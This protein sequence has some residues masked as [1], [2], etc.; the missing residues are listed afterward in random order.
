MAELAEPSL[1]SRDVLIRVSASSINI[2]DIHF[3]EGTF[4]GG[5]PL[6]PR[7]KPHAPVTP[8]SDVA[9][10]VVAVGRHVQSVQVGDAVFGVQLPFRRGGAWAELC[11]VDERWITRKPEHVSFRDAAACGVSGLV[12]LFAMN[13]M[14]IRAGQQI[15]ILGVTGGIGTIAAQL[16]I[17]AGAKVIGVCGTRNIDRAYRL[18]C[19]LVMDYSQGP[20]DH[21][22]R[23]HGITSVDRVLD[24][25]GGRHNERMGQSILQ[26]HGAY[27]TVVGPERFVGDRRLGW[28]G[29]LANLAHVGYRS[30]SSYFRGPRYILT[31]PGLNAGKQLPNIAAAASAGVLP[32]IDSTVPFELAPI[33]D[34]LRRAVAHSNTGRIVIE[35]S[36]TPTPE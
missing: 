10:V 34:A 27:V 1:R 36:R 26:H 30:I 31:G 11:A 3:A 23:E 20:W 22:L 21:L 19:S 9:G 7:P 2:D 33:R 16:A 24:L 35:I 4:Y 5:L 6:G 29:I 14:K 28:T 18:G 32:A 25:V 13:A 12:A 17:R 8:G 15:V